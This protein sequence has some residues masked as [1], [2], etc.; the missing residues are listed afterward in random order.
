MPDGSR[1]ILPPQPSPSVKSTGI[2][3]LDVLLKG[4]LPAN[5]MYLVEGDPGTGKTT[6]ALQ[7]LLEGA[8]SRRGGPVR[9]A[10]GDHRRAARRR[11]LARLVARRHRAVP[12]AD[13]ARGRRR[14]A[15]HALPS[16]GGRAR[17]RR[18]E[19][20]SADRSS[21]LRPSR[22]VSTRCQR[23]EAAGARSAALPPPDPGAQGVTSP[24]GTAPSCCST[25]RRRRR[26]SAAAE[27]VPRR[28]AARA[29]AV[30][31]RPGAPARCA[32]SSSAASPAVEGFHDFT[33][34]RGGVAVF[35]QLLAAR[36]GVV[37]W[38]EPVASG[39]A[40]LDRACSAAG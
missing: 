6:L 27:P 20:C 29:A 7:F 37:R 22:I 35:P 32:S 4:G 31:L 14:G 39:I 17:A 28:D 19:R 8:R 23:A 9:G 30:R 5:R 18:S 1:A 2:A 10:V 21:G 25:I 36:P 38:T 3:G 12:A 26:R 33:I 15:V 24:A 11:R 16:G 34:S 13:A 40:E